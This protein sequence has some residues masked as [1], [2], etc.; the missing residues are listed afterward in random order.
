MEDESAE[1]AAALEKR[2]RRALRRAINRY[3][4]RRIRAVP[5]LLERLR[6]D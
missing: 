2:D 1:F 5:D 3:H 6:Q 4:R